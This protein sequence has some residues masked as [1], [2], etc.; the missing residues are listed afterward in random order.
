VTGA[1]ADITGAAW[2][3]PHASEPTDYGTA[4][5]ILAVRVGPGAPHED[6][7][8]T[9]LLTAAMA[10]LRRHGL[11]VA[12]ISVDA[13]DQELARACRLLGFRHD[14]TDTEYTL[15]PLDAVPAPDGV[16]AGSG[17]PGKESR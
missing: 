7:I 4:A 6:Q 17:S 11:R 9:A 5:R 14:Q 8:R 3:D 13:G 2:F 16:R 12:L 1:D 15:S 10:G